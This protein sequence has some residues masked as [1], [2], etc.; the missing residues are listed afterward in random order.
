MTRAPSRY[1]LYTDSFPE[2]IV[3]SAF[4]LLENGASAIR[5][6]RT[7]L[8]VSGT[9]LPAERF[10]N[11]RPKTGDSHVALG[12]YV[13]GP[14]FDRRFVW[15][16]WHSGRVHRDC[17]DSVLRLPGH[18]CGDAPYGSDARP[19]HPLIEAV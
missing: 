15:L 10:I 13:P 7:C 1:S 19:R 4:A 11:Q 12:A 2:I 3:H 14:R 8:T 9:S 18:L 5:S 16:Y 17:E 6:A